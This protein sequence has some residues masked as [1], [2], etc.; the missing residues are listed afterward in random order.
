MK[1]ESKHFIG[2]WHYGVILT[3][4]SLLSGFASII[5]CALGYSLWGVFCLLLSGL[6]DA[7]DG[8]VAST[9]KN[10]SE[11]DKVFGS[12]ID[13]LSDFVS[14]GV[15]PAMIGWSMGMKQWYFV[16]LLAVFVLNALVRLAYYN[17]D[18]YIKVKNNVTE[19][20]HYY[21]GL[22]V[23]IISIDLP[24][25]FMIARIFQKSY[26]LVCSL[27]LSISFLAHA[28]LSVFRFKMPK[29]GVKKLIVFSVLL[30]AVVAGLFVLSYFVE[31]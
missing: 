6:C 25:I 22:P 4:I 31:L 18:E 8:A 1:I 26:P 28:F 10:R 11:A 14:F 13:S 19:K 24:I 16:V 23:T 5:C 30:V 29:M 17:T 2:Y 21:E 3:Y 27:I 15:A 9:R 12:Q 7:F 20:R